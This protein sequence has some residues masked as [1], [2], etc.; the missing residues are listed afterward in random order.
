MGYPSSVDTVPPA[1]VRVARSF[2]ATARNALAAGER[3]V[4]VCDGRRPLAR[5]V[6]GGFA[7]D[8]WNFQFFHDK[9]GTMGILCDPASPALAQFPTESHSDWQWFQMTLHAQPLILDTLMPAGDRP[10]VQ[11]IDNYN[12]CHKLGLVF[13]ARVG[14]GRLL[15][16]AT[17]L[18]ALV[19]SARKPA[20]CSPAF[21]LMPGRTGSIRARPCRLKR[22][23][24]V[25][26]DHS[27]D[28]LHGDGFL[29]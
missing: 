28:R 20:N 9:P 24:A 1:G 23:A 16:C 26:C 6:G 27:D 4:L 15:V 10:I 3:V 12:R 13:E 21:S 11:V 5:T 17:D 22:C 8:F 19:R 14:P 2:D 18:L 29:L 7:S 25:P